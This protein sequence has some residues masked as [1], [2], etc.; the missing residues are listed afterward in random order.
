MREDLSIQVHLMMNELKAS[1]SFGKTEMVH[2]GRW[3]ARIIVGF[4]EKSDSNEYFENL[5]E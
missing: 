2:P 4:K 1:Q 3:D 5:K